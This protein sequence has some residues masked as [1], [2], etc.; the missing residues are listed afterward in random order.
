M[1]AEMPIAMR[2][3]LARRAAQ[4]DE[5]AFSRLAT[6]YR[7]ALAQHVRYRGVDADRVDDVVQ[8]TLLRAW[9]TRASYASNGSWV[10]WCQRIATH[11]IIDEWRRETL[12]E[13]VSLD[14][15]TPSA[16]D[17]APMP[18]DLVDPA[19][20]PD[21]ALVAKEQ[22]ERIQQALRRLPFSQQTAMR[23]RLEGHSFEDIAATLHTARNTVLIYLYRARIA[24]RAMLADAQNRE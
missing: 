12:A 11:L 1:P 23:M 17:D 21:T 2:E 20:L 14:A 8:E 19:P 3:R 13:F 22:A 6:H 24:L 10:K 18:N 15:V 16:D 9:E 4:G 7:P 5:Q